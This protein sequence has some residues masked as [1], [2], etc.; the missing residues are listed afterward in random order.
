MNIFQEAAVDLAVGSNFLPQRMKYKFPQQRNDVSIYLLSDSF[1]YDIQ[2]IKDAPIPKNDYKNIIIPFKIVDRFGNRIYRY[3]S[4][5]NEFTRKVNYI[6]QQKMIPPII[7]IRYPYPKVIIDNLYIS[8][9]E[10]MKTLTPN[11][12]SMS[13]TMIKD[14][15]FDI[16]KRFMSHL[17]FSKR[18][19]LLIDT[20][21]YTIYKNPTVDMYKSDLIN[22]LLTA[23]IYLPPEKI[24]KLEWTLIFRGKD[25][26]YKFDLMNFEKRDVPRMRA[27]LDKIGKENP[28]S[29]HTNEE[30]ESPFDKKEEEPTLPTLEE[31]TDDDE[32]GMDIDEEL[33]HIVHSNEDSVKTI[34]STIMSLKKKFNVA[35]N[36]SS[37]NDDDIKQSQL[38]QAKTMD[39]NAELLNRIHNIKLDTTNVD[40]YQKISDEIIPSGTGDIEKKKLQ[41]AA[42]KVAKTDVTMKNDTDVLNSVS[43]AREEE[44]RKKVGQIKLN[45]ITFDSLT[46]VT[47]VPIP[48]ASVPTDVV[49]TN[50][51]VTR[52]SKFASVTK[53]YED[54]LLDRDIVSVF[55]NFSKLPD[56]FYVT[57]IEVTDV[58]TVT[59]MINNWRITLRNKQTDR[60]SIINIR[61]PKIKNGRFYNNGIWYNIGKQDFPIPILKIGKSTVIITSNYQ[62]ITVERY[63]TKSLVDIGMLVK[64]IDKFAMEAGK[65]KYTKAGISSNTNSKFI[66]TIEYDEYAQRWLHFINKE[67]QLEIYF[68]RVQCLKAYSFVTVNQNEFCCGMHNKVPIV[69]NT[70]TGLT[71]DGK[72]LTDIMLNSLPEHMQTAY[73][74]QKPG[75]L[76]MYTSITIGVTI[77]LGVG[78]CAWEGMSTLLKK[79]GCKYQYVD[80]TFNDPHYFMIPFKDKILAI[81]NTVPNQLIFN[82]FYRINTKAYN[83]AD[84]EIPIMSSNSVFIDIFNQQ[85]FKQ[86]SQLTTFITYYRFFVDPITADVCDHFNIPNDISGMLVYASNLL[87]D[88]H[89]TSENRASLYRIRSTEI[90]PAIIHYRLAFAI[91]KYNNASGSQSRDN[92]L[93]FNPNEVINELL[94]VPNVEPMS[95][96]NPAVEL[97]TRETITKKGFKGVNSERSYTIKKRS[98]EDTM[99]GKI[100]ISTSVYANVGIVR[101]LSADPKITSVRGYTSSEGAD[102]KYDDLSLASFSELLTPGVVARDDA[103]RTAM[104]CSQSSHLVPIDSSQ[105]VLISNGVDE[106]VPAYLS[107]EFSYI[108]EDDGVV[109]DMNEDYM[110]LRYKNGEKRA[111]HIGHTQSFNSGSGFYVD[112]KL[113]PNV[114]VN[115]KFKRGDILAYHSRF[116]NKD[117]TGVVR[118]N[119]GP[120]LKVAFLGNYSTYEDAGAVTQSMSKKMKSSL[121]MAQTIKIN[122][123]DDIDKIVEVGTEVEYGDPLVVFGLGDTGDKSV[124]NFLKAFQTAGGNHAIDIA[125]HAKRVITAKHSGTVVDVK[126]YTCKSLDKLSPS[127]FK[128][129]T[130]YFKE[131]VKKRQI[132]DKYDKTNSVYKMGTLYMLPTE[133]LKGTTIK[134]ITT[135]V[136]IEIYIEHSDEASAGDKITVYGANK[137]VISEVIPAG[138][139]PYSEDNP[140]EEISMF[141]TPGAVMKR[142]IPSVIIIASGNKC[143]VELKK[144]VRQIWNQ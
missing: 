75:K 112:N 126:M 72:S 97:H 4:T 5:Q 23:Y 93:V 16:F 67:D 6:N 134:G 25:V 28:T 84:F 27:M 47:D 86:Y 31:E 57:N 30:A 79:A 34:N 18:K 36:P 119:I 59:S 103:P 118:M 141:A 139:E 71:R 73:K 85:F 80:K 48:K 58:S 17:S 68:N 91:S 19:I 125:E 94:A 22:A 107:E 39:V 90:I 55:M 83:T 121:S 9:S 140:N 3:I 21:R 128:I 120:L 96:L 37:E 81:E 56:G 127:L 69:V 42:K 132:L 115:D 24:K 144:Q 133:P 143:L 8:I 62:K 35:D 76:S 66:S 122:A 41:E 11:I 138:L 95:A 110:V 116:F 54:K 40:V 49:S 74:Q 124:D 99:I 26:D 137:Q 7:P 142:M 135:D 87:A 77:P 65:S 98:Y 14:E 64:V 114:K 131:N 38:Y 89:F 136:L 60:Q 88:N 52:G 51:M 46:S 108:A 100:A 2:M 33:Q 61:I 109:L 63:D 130:Q 10:I 53:A 113:E 1:E 111:V 82:G 50:E 20:Q 105:P 92:K 13:Q 70:D 104:A 102:G 106:I 117:S 45:N 129:F 101:Q 12:R 32:G 43:T 123:S 78:I 29:A 44:I 15:I